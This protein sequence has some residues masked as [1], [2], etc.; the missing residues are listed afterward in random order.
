MRLASEEPHRRAALS[1]LSYHLPQD[2]LCRFLE[3]CRRVLDRACDAETPRAPIG[4]L[5]LVVD[6]WEGLYDL[7]RL[8]THVD[9]LSFSQRRRGF[10]AARRT[11]LQ[12]GRASGAPW[13]LV[14]DADGQHDPDAIERVLAE[15]EQS[16]WEAVIPQRSLVD[17]PL[18]DDG[19]IDRV[20]AE[21]FE[22]FVVAR[23]VGRDEMIDKDLQPGLFLLRPVAADLLLADTRSRRY[24]WD[25]EAAR[26][27]L[28][29]E[30]R[31]GF[32]AV[33]TRPQPI[34]FFCAA[35]SVANVRYLRDL[36]G[37]ARL[38]AELECFRALAAVRD[39]FREPALDGLVVHV[40]EALDD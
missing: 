9:V 34:T 24:E 37:E 36:V 26:C 23:S 3:G 16:D 29:S 15:A 2:T 10:G 31:V 18:R 21:R 7:A 1:A 19:A 4:W 39:A 35:D 38:R 14:V 30:L 5:T 11:A 20:L 6:E 40:G 27:L 17:L 12:E 13:M 33:E 28:G 22:A 32:P 25:L 8:A